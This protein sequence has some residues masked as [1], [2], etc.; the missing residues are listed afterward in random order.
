M[1]K[2]CIRDRHKCVNNVFCTQIKFSYVIENIYT[3][4]TLAE[5][6]SSDT[7]FIYISSTNMVLMSE[8]KKCE[9]FYVSALQNNKSAQSMKLMWLCREINEGYIG[10]LINF[11]SQML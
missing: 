10:I 11:L 7:W 2:M 8:N 3:N 9:F 4:H 5:S 6:F 1:Q